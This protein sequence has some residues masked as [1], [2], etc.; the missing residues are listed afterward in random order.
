MKAGLDHL[1]CRSIGPHLPL[2]G[3]LLKAAERAREIGANAV[4]VFTDNPASWRRRA[5]QP[6]E[7][8]AFRERLAEYG[9]GPLA[10]HAPYLI[11][12]C[13]SKEDFW[14][15]SCVTLANELKVGRLYGAS[16]V[17]AHVGSHRGHSRE[18]GIERLALG[19]V[20]VLEEAPQPGPLLVLENSAGTGDGVGS[21][22]EDLADIAAAA[23]RA[24]VDLERVGFCLDTAHLW[25]AGYPLDEPDGVDRL[26]GRIE[27][28]IGRQK[29]VMLHLNDSRTTRGSRLDRHEHIGA[30]RIGVE[31]LRRLLCDPWLGTLPTYLETPGMDVGYDAV[32]LERVRLIIAGEPLPQ[33]PPEAFSVRG[34]RSR[35]GTPPEVT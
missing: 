7:L 16:F 35:A 31:G 26:V 29:V 15:S 10:V 28:L 11:N 19:L 33:L 13:G 22:L 9:I 20:R 27:E 8:E 34:S 30:G 25:G 17:V 12:L 2:S 18:V 24:G 23:E 32:N 21:T 5:E 14:D 4:Q 6:A 1:S 3:G